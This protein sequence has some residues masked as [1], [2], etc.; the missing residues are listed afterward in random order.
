MWCVSHSSCREVWTQRRRSSWKKMRRGSSVMNTGTWTCRSLKLKSK[1]RLLHRNRLSLCKLRSE[2]CLFHFYDFKSQT[3]KHNRTL[4][5]SFCGNI[6]SHRKEGV[7]HVGFK[8][9]DN[10]SVSLCLGVCWCLDLQNDWNVHF[11]LLMQTRYFC[12]VMKN[13]LNSENNVV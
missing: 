9:N 11:T 3:Y 1:S 13:V 2:I 6:K 5:V 10:E 4:F 7:I 12:L 8:T